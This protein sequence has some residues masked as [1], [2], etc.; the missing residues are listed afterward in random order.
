MIPKIIHFIWF[1]KNTKEFP[2][3]AQ[4][5]MD[6]C[7]EKMPDYEI[8]VWNQE[9]IDFTDNRFANEAYEEGFYAFVSDYV[10]LLVL[11]RYGGIYLDTDVEI[12]KPLDE[13][14][15]S[16]GFMGFELENQLAT[17]IIGA[18]AENPVIKTFL[19]YYEDEVFVHGM[20][21]YNVRPN[22]E[23]VTK[24]LVRKGLILNGERQTVAGIDIY[25]MTYFCPVN[26]YRENENLM[27]EN[28][29][30]DHHFAASWVAHQNEKQK[31]YDR[32]VE[33]FCKLLGKHYGEKL[34]RVYLMTKYMGICDMVR[35]FK[36]QKRKRK[37]YH[38]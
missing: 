3:N 31:E 10:R 27:S 38:F 9:N 24:I 19:D 1:D 4:H 26:C 34:C 30:V 37:Y 22:T 14:C 5:Y 8:K 6:I 28:S 11:Y 33:Q 7:R 12:R 21:M 18:E 32:K 25:P 15:D 13:F 36:K 17:H 35:H 29:Y 20:G 2:A 23:I 16:H